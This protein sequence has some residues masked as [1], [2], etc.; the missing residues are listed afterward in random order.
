MGQACN[1][2]VYLR[3]LINPAERSKDID[4]KLGFG[5]FSPFFWFMRLFPSYT[6]AI[7]SIIFCL[8]S[9]GTES[10]RNFRLWLDFQWTHRRSMTPEFSQMPGEED[11]AGTQAVSEVLAKKLSN[12]SLN[13]STKLPSLPPKRLPQKQ[14]REKNLKGSG[15]GLSQVMLYKRRWGVRTAEVFGKKGHK[16]WFKLLL[17]IPHHVS[18]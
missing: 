12:L 7:L 11:S 3:N 15:L 1:L 14:D 9:L 5:I 17:Y 16:G 4:I 8:N 13:P 10:R 6:V 18:A 2:K